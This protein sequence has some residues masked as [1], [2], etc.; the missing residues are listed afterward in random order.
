MRV[1]GGESEG[2]KSGLLLQ[3]PLDLESAES[4]R[5]GLAEGKKGLS[6]F[7]KL[8]VGDCSSDNEPEQEGE[9]VLDVDALALAEAVG[10]VDRLAD[11]VGLRLSGALTEARKAP[12]G[13]GAST[14]PE[15]VN[16]APIK[17]EEEYAPV[18]VCCAEVGDNRAEGVGAPILREP[19]FDAV[20]HGEGS[21]E[22]LTERGAEALWVADNQAE[23]VPAALVVRVVA[24]DGD[25]D[26]NPEALC[27]SAGDNDVMITMEALS[28]GDAD[29]ALDEEGVRS[30]DKDEV[31][32]SQGA[33]VKEGGADALPPCML[34]EGDGAHGVLERGGEV[35]AEPPLTLAETVGRVVPL[36]TA[37]R[38]GGPTLGE[39]VCEAVK[40]AARGW[41]R[42]AWREGLAERVACKPGEALASADAEPP[43]RRAADALPVAQLLALAA[44]EA[45]PAPVDDAGC[46]DGVPRCE[47]APLDVADPREEGEPAS[48][49]DAVGAPLPLAKT[50]ERDAEG[51]LVALREGA[52]AV[53]VASRVR[54]GVSDPSPASPVEGD[55][56]SDTVGSAE[57]RG[58]PL[59]QEQGRAL[60]DAGALSVARED[61]EPRG[62]YVATPAPL[63][64]LL[65]EGGS[66][67]V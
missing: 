28:L 39:G 17:C 33:G 30:C 21:A 9:R 22:R 44:G 61:G 48:A 65:R 66:R 25:T 37:L 58:E 38:D 40:D 2:E 11:G 63:P 26:A 43:A 10:S 54:P 32:L 53:G 19:R 23:L 50:G 3:H 5:K 41:D 47:A 6:E 52:C 8:G 16:E 29:A 49:E 14:V 46:A 34:D 31:A 12:L 4:V 35:L 7:E 51:V 24:G 20:A 42:V 64:L 59:A 56:A 45:D 62:E 1:R 27:D 67:A 13:V 18:C 55:D 60:A 57:A 36:C 15:A